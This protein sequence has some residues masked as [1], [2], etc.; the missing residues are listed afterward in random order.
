DEVDVIRVKED[1]G[2]S[3]ATRS[4]LVERANKLAEALA[5]LR[6]GEYGICQECGEPIAPARLRAM[7]EVLTCVRS[8]RRLAPAGAASVGDEGDED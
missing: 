4:L 6:G 7:P 8:T 5:G 2:M 3:F 1:R